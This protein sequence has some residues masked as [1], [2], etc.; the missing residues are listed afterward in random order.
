MP[1]ILDNL[2]QPIETGF[3]PSP[4]KEN[5][6]SLK[7]FLGLLKDEEDYYPR[8]QNNTQLMI[9]RLRKVFY[10]QWGW[11]TQVIRGAAKIPGRYEVKMVKELG[12][13]QS[14]KSYIKNK[15]D[16]NYE[17]IGLVPEVVY[18]KTDKQYPEKAGQIPEIYAND[19]QEVILPNDLYCDIGHILTGLDACNYPAP[20]S[21]LPNFLMFLHKLLPHVNSNMDFATWLGDIASSAG[22]FLFDELQN[23][24]Y[25]RKNEQKEINE[26]SPGSDMLGNIDS[27]LISRLYNIHTNLGPRVT[28]IIHDY[29]YDNGI[30]EYY[31]QRRCLYFCKIMGLK[32]W[33]GSEFSNETKWIKYQVKQLRNATA[34]YVYGDLE[35]FTGLWL[36]L[37]VWLR[38]FEKKLNF[39]LLI[40]LFL[41]ALKQEI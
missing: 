1:V 7:E 24:K 17:F 5:A 37:K 12:K 13:T 23:R 35:N 10:D 15:R 34:F 8:E 32:D 38:L 2:T 26:Y 4:G 3:V 14:P 22:N 39:K 36:A 33:N 28:Q 25:N 41:D 21:P 20:I 9:T 30:G 27:Y 18:K 6:I 31:R 11:S 40:K 29:Y 19:N 16:K